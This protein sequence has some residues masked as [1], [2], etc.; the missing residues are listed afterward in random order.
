MAEEAP[1]LISLCM[2]ALTQQLLRPFDDLLLPSIYHLPSHLLNTFIARLPPFALR[3]F[4]HHLPFG[5]DGF[6]RDHS[7]NK[8]KRAGFGLESEFSLGEVVSPALASARSA[9]S[10][11]GLAA[12]LLG[13]AFA[14]VC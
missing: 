7:T 8:R 10:A 11:N 6:S 4:Q 5:E 14:R 13:N 3:I 12:N 2:D 1:S 9:D